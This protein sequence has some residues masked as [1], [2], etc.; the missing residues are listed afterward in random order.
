[1]ELSREM[2]PRGRRRHRADLAGE[3]G[4]VAL[5][6]LRPGLALHVRRERDA[7]VPLE[8]D[9]DGEW[10]HEPD[11][12]AA[13]RRRIHD[14]YA[15]R[16]RD[17]DHPPRLQL[18]AGPNERLPERVAF[19]EGAEEQDLGSGTG[20]LS[21]HETRREDARLV[22]HEDVAGGDQLQQVAEDTVFDR[23]VGS[24]QHE[25]PALVAA[26]RGILRDPIAG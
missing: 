4:L 19:S 13:V 1:E 11:N 18:A 2:E 22:Q 14:L 12:A 26:L 8:R 6:V 10:R 25:E 23:A 9:L 17:L 20:R 15:Q 3:D 16:I 21:A 5:G 7:S 24:M